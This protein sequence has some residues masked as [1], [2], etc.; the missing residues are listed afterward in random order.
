MPDMRDTSIMVTNTSNQFLELASMVTFQIEIG[1]LK[2]IMNLGMNQGV[3][4]ELMEEKGSKSDP[5]AEFLIDKIIEN[6][7]G[8]KE[9]L[10]WVPDQSN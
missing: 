6:L 7:H 1:H 4:G 9:E 8:S 2:T 10:P 5:R 3:R